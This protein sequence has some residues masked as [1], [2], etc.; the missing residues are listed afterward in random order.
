LHCL[1]N[2]FEYGCGF[3]QNLVAPEAQHEQPL[4]GQEGTALFVTINGIWGRVLTAVEFDH[5]SNF[6]TGEVGEIGADRVLAAEL[7]TQQTAIAQLGPQQTFGI[8]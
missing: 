4:R 3:S 7:E 2:L 1:K 5:Q 6:K 8:G